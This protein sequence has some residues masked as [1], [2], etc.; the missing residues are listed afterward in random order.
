MKL[1][2][3]IITALTLILIGVSCETALEPE[4]FSETAPSNLFSSLTGVEAV[5]N[6]AHAHLALM[7]G[8]NSAQQLSAEEC[9]T[10]IGYADLGA[11]ANWATDFRDFILDGVSSS[12]YSAI[13]N[14]PYQ[15]V[16]NT[17]ILIENVDEADISEDQKVL[18]KAEA[19]F[20]RA[21]A[22]WKLYKYFG[23]T[24]LRTSTEQEL[25]IPRATENEFISFIED[26]LIAVIPD[27]P[28]PG[29]ESQWGRAHKGA[30]MGYLCEMYLNTKQWQKCADIANDVINMNYYSLFPNYFELFMV[31][32]ERNREII[33]ARTA[34]ADLGR[35]ANISFMNFAWPTGFV[36][37]P[38]TGLEF[39]EGCRNFATMLYIR[40]EFWFSFE[41]ND[42]RKSLMLTTYINTSGDTIN[43]L[44]PNDHV[45]PFK[46]WPADDFE[47]PG[48]G[49]DIPEFR[50]AD[51]LLSRAEALN[52][53]NGP[54]QES[55]D[56][57]NEVRERAGLRYLLLSEFPSKEAL[58][59]HI[60][61]ERGWEF[62]WEGKRRQ[63]LIRHGEFI[64]RAQERGLPAK[65]HHVRHPIPQFALEANP[66]LEQN[67]GYS[68]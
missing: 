43:L 54:N 64:K 33:W 1:K 3:K 21:A 7:N 38:I 55:I 40:D 56:L 49:N 26:E 16:R 34:K 41:P 18:I 60:L 25:E 19:R 47:G 42:R 39:C 67:E 65:P 48:Y 23:P 17:N 52:E 28:D 35:S 14:R 59:S 5:L 22:Y 27:L 53:I 37:D 30:A 31:K 51:I 20:I 4:V 68:N 15:A 58:R 36:K 44:P 66:L 29:N 9:M 8:N 61:D 45:R 62:W 2:N 32:N 63:D 57:I 11:V 24:P 50:Y 10:D 6:G 46:Y 13:W 12:V